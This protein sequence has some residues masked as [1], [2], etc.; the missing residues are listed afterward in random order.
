M[1]GFVR[2][3]HSILIKEQHMPTLNVVVNIAEGSYATLIPSKN[4]AITAE[5]ID[6]FVA[7][8]KLHILSDKN[9]N[10][11]PVQQEKDL[12]LKQVN[13]K[14]FTV[15]DANGKVLYESNLVKHNAINKLEFEEV[16]REEESNQVTELELKLKE[17]EELN[18]R[19]V[20]LQ[21]EISML[22][23]K[24][25]ER[26]EERKKELEEEQK[27]Y[28]SLIKQWSSAINNPVQSV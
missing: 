20:L 16:I 23:N 21:E 10:D 9:F 26:I 25:V 3:R 11:H 4:S 28:E 18:N 17:L 6:E 19:R 2:K 5:N 7:D 13:N 22:V 12:L 8:L 15:K 14:D 1:M 24:E 27:R